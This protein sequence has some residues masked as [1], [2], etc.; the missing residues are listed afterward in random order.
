MWKGGKG[1]GGEECGEGR[2][3]RKSWIKV[4][5]YHVRYTQTHIVGQCVLAYVYVCWQWSNASSCCMF[6]HFSASLGVTCHEH[7][8]SSKQYTYIQTHTHTHCN[9]TR[10]EDEEGEPTLLYFAWISSSFSCFCPIPVLGLVTRYRCFSLLASFTRM[11]TDRSQKYFCTEPGTGTGTDTT[12]P[13]S[14]LYI[15]DTL[16]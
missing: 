10:G 4:S 15:E 3:E 12:V 5:K 1:R 7:T 13:A 14:S 8:I 11:A 9:S 16:Q 6:H 2:E